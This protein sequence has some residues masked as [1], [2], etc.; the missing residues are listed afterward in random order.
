MFLRIWVWLCRVAMWLHMRLDLY[1]WKSAAYR[2]LF[3]RRFAAY[4]LRPYRS[5][6]ELAAFLRSLTWVSDGWRQLWDAISYP[7]KVEYVGSGGDR[8][9]GDCDEFAIYAA[10][11]VSRSVEEGV[12]TPEAKTW[13]LTVTW[14][15]GFKPGG[16]NVCLL[17]IPTE[18][19]HRRYAYMD[20]G[21]PVY[22]GA[23]P[24]VVRGVLARYTDRAVCIGWTLS[25]PE[26]LHCVEHHWDV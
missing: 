13:L 22:F 19:P 18:P 3:E 25:N 16:H 20:Y 6:R 8:R 9:V 10:V 21:M 24:A 1:R 5:F 23:V 26:T 2:A 11:A 7:G 17:E 4:P 15:K 12:F 14:L